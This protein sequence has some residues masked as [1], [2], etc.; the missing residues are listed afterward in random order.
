MKVPEVCAGMAKL[1][2]V[3]DEGGGQFEEDDEQNSSFD[4]T[5]QQGLESFRST[6]LTRRGE[7]EITLDRIV[8]EKRLVA[9]MKGR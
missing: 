6:K 1:G 9:V 5:N 4:S 7:I 8:R 2:A 3:D